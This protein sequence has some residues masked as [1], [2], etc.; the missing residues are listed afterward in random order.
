MTSDA[1]TCP[2]KRKTV[3][4][5]RGLIRAHQRLRGELSKA[6]AGKPVLVVPERARAALRQIAELLAFLGANFDEAALREIR[7]KPQG[8]MHNHLGMPTLS[9]ARGLIRLH[10]RL[11][12]EL[13]KSKTG[14]RVIVPAP[15]ARRLVRAIAGLMPILGITFDPARL[16]SIRTRR[17]VGPF[18]YGGLRHGILTTLRLG[19]HWMSYTE[20]ATTLLASRRVILAHDRYRHFL[21]KLR[22]AVLFLRRRG[23]LDAES[24]VGIRDGLT[25][26]RWRIRPR[27][28]PV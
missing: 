23:R 8:R 12:G 7:V 28:V 16:R 21:Q 6:R 22:E 9:L 17:S 27:P 24:A 5:S 15:K 10:M 3:G 11:C 1:W 25:R 14:E 4:L 19:S 20:I 13:E 26:Q 2:L 18:E